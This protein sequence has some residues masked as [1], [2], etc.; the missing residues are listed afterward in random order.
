MK[1][2]I[3]IVIFLLLISFNSWAQIGGDYNPTNPTDPGNP[4]QEY[5]LTLK[6]TPTNGG[7]F[8]VSSTNI[9]GGKTYTLRA[10]PNTDFAFV[11]WICNGDTLSK[12]TSYTYTMPFHDVEMTGAFIYS[13]SN[14]S[15]PNVITPKHKL[16]LKAI[17]TDGGS[18]NTSSTSVS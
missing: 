11:A 10:Y 16:T 13:P 12:S 17:P 8:N 3:S 2:R 4:T 1:N 9:A 7:S 18:F 6:S 14:P 5:T 15:D